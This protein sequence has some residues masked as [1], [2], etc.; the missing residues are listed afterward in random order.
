MRLS[1]RVLIAARLT[2]AALAIPTACRAGDE[3]SSRLTLRAS[4]DPRTPVALPPEG[5]QEVLREMRAMLGA[6]GGAMA[7]AASRD[8]VALLA[9]LAPAGTAAAAD[10]ALEELLPPAWRELAERTHGGFDSLTAAVRRIRGEGLP[11]TVLAR[12]G[13]L[14]GTCT[15]C[16]D[17]FRITLR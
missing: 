15:A 6:M 11:D 9:A 3:E 14:T 8:T 1:S 5:Q 4:L 10:P 13:Q 12:L 2:V 17:A 7:A 16:H